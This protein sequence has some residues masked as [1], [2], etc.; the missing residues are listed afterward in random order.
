MS[1]EQ[2]SDDV[3][4]VGVAD[5]P[6]VF[7]VWLR[8]EPKDGL[9]GDLQWLCD[10]Y[11]DSHVVMD[12]AALGSLEAANYKMLLDL[13]E[14]VKESDFRFLLCGLSPHLKWQL[15]CVRLFDRFDTVDTREA[16]IM[17]LTPQDSYESR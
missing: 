8:E 1:V 10:E 4:V 9:A 12:L 17:A 15:K 11:M 14:L 16:A 6:S 2:Y 3:I 13:Q 7:K 5:G